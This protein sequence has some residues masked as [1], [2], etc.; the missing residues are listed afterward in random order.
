[1]VGSL[2]TVSAIL[3]FRAE[4]FNVFNHTD[5]A[6]LAG[7]PLRHTDRGSNDL[8]DKAGHGGDPKVMNRARTV[9][10]AT[11]GEQVF[12]ESK[13]VSRQEYS[14]DTHALEHCLGESVS[15][16]KPYIRRRLPL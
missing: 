15:V 13:Q 10:G 16:F 6:N 9:D 12:E 11:T 7:I 5:L 1:M 2:Q 14:D 3:Q 4:A 8:W